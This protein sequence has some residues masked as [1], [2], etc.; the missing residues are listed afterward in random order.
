[1]IDAQ[2]FRR[3][4][5]AAAVAAMFCTLIVTI[6]Y[7]KAEPL[8]RTEAVID[9]P[10]E[11]PYVGEMLLLRLRSFIGAPVAAHEI[12]QPDLINFDWQQF[13]RDSPVST[14]INGVTVAGIE[15]VIAIYPR[16]AGRLTIEPFTRKVEL[17]APDNSRTETAFTSAPVTLDVRAHDGL[18]KPGDWWLPAKSVTIADHWDPRPDR[19]GLNETS[20]RTITIEA[21]GLTADRLPP[22]P[23][24]RAP[25]VIVFAA[26]AERATITTDAGPVARAVYRYDVR[27][28]SSDPAKMPAVHIPW[29][30]VGERKMRDAAIPAQTVAFIDPTAPMRAAAPEKGS[31]LSSWPIAVGAA[32]FVWTAALAFFILTSPSWREFLSSRF[33]PA[34]RLMRDMR[35]AARAGDF[36]AFRAATLALARLDGARWRR[37][38]SAPEIADAIAAIDAR[39]FG[40]ESVAAAPDLSRLAKQ[41]GVAWRQAAIPTPRQTALAP[42]DG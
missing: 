30:D 16:S 23:N 38:A 27:P 15:R 21:L 19:L 13:G 4:R 24:M 32:S 7:A 17:I 37:A 25:G 9:G 1:M 18:G 22:P 34:G 20:R 2:I 8:N 6:P 12:S 35:R 29:F 10:K 40:R 14:T 5:L 26:P 11:A 41:I 33:G 3:R 31:M 36:S 42:L 39:L 28:I